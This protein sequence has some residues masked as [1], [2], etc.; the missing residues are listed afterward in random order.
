MDS[1][2]EGSMGE[3]GGTGWLARTVQVDWFRWRGWLPLP[4]YAGVLCFTDPQ[5]VHRWAALLGSSLTAFGLVLRTLA[6]FELGRSS[7][8]R[9][10][11]CR[12]LATGGI[13][14]WSRNPIYVGN[15]AIASGLAV[16]A[17]TGPL[18]AVLALLLA[19]HYTRV[20]QQEERHLAGVFP[21]RY[22]QY[23]REVGRF[24]PRRI[25]PALRTRLGHVRRELRIWAGVGMAIAV[26]AALRHF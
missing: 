12:R 1:T 21:E 14:A 23:S 20:V 26:L 19:L 11:H 10:L 2:G 15:I 5:S 13:Y 9:R 24:V 8:T 7:D 17:G 3:L 4:L 18:A 6:R 16:L 22:A 25:P